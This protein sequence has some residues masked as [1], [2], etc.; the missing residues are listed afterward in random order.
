MPNP[1]GAS[2]SGRRPTPKSSTARAAPLEGVASVAGRPAK[3]AELVARTIAQD[4]V[5]QRVA[6]G[7]LIDVEDD[8]VKRLGVSRGTL[9]EGLRLLEVLG[10]VESRIGRSGGVVVQRPSAQH[11]AQIVTF[12]LQFSGCTYRQLLE[13]YAEVTPLIMGLVARNASASDVQR[14]DEALAVFDALPIEQQVRQVPAL[15]SVYHDMLDN[16]MWALLAKSFSAVISGHFE[17]LLVPES[18]WPRVVRT[19]RKTA[20]AVRAGDVEG[21]EKL[22]RT[23]VAAWRRVAEASQRELLDSPIVWATGDNLFGYRSGL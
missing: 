8:L 9:R 4:L 6:P 16:P 2:G 20:A 5:T 10:V 14:I 1:R 17:A 11:F 15:N 13:V 18:E 19:V 23:Q 21:A 22:A 3:K 12:Y 7:S